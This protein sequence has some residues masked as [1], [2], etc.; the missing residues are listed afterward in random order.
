MLKKFI[1]CAIATLGYVSFVQA[2]YKLEKI[3]KSADSIPV[4]E[5]VLFSKSENVLY[6]SQ[7][8][9]KGNEKDSVGAIGKLNPDGTTINL[10]WV[11]GLNAP[12]GLGLYKNKL[13]VAD[14]TEVVVINIKKAAII[15]R[16]AV[17]ETVFLNDITIDKK[18]VVYVS[19]TRKN[20]VFRIVKNKPELYLDNVTS[21]N[22]LK[23]IDKD[24]YILAGTELWKVNDA[25]QITKI[26]SGFEKVGDGIEP[27]GNGDFIVTCWAGILY[28]VK[29]DG[30]FEKLLDVQGKM[31][32]ADLGYDNK[33]R[34]IYI[35]TFN[36]NSVK[37]YQLK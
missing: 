13:Y 14:L 36:A 1:L 3:W 20:K 25:K 12:K 15:N 9:G 27:V 37:A 22:G 8:D 33:N 28:Y 17:P 21:A 4:P 16:I 10:N 35:P 7:I 24:L 31:N 26:A 19:D 30:T 11:T 34:I 18:G 6:V 29:A 2:Q 23:A 5:S 32:T